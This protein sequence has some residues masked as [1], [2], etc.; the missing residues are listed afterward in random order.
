MLQYSKEKGASA[1][2]YLGK[3]VTTQAQAD[4]LY[5]NRET[6]DFLS[7]EPLLERIDMSKIIRSTATVIIGAE[8]GNRKGKVIPQ[9]SWVDEI[10]NLADESGIRVFMKGSLREIMG[11]DFR[12]DSLPWEV[13][14]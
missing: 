7:V 3:S 6:T 13:R 2:L 10:V 4:I 11:D 5:R 14:R 9:K 1:M 8:T 12:Q